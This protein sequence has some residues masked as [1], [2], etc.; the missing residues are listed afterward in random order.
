MPSGQVVSWRSWLARLLNIYGCFG[1]LRLTEEVAGSNPAEINSFLCCFS[2]LFLFPREDPTYALE[3]DSSC[4]LAH[5]LQC[6]LFITTEKRRSTAQVVQPAK[7]GWRRGG[8]Q[9]SPVGSAVHSS[10][11]RKCCP[12]RLNGKVEPRCTVN[13][14]FSKLLAA[15]DHEQT[16]PVERE[17]VSSAETVVQRRERWHLF[18]GR[19]NFGPKPSRGVD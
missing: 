7:H 10:K 3:V 19:E 14:S 6:R 18:L 5:A 16:R 11:R 1:S 8:A 12:K 17:H 4:L 15:A 2:W 9:H 13:A